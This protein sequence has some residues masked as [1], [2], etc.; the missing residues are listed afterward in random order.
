MT[1]NKPKYLNLTTKETGAEILRIPQNYLINFN[2]SLYHVNWIQQK[3]RT[4]TLH[5]L[6]TRIVN[7]KKCEKRTQFKSFLNIRNSICLKDNFFLRRLS[8]ND[9]SRHDQLYV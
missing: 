7:S 4:V 1:Q 2:F 8:L 6:D 3:Y 5:E 9:K